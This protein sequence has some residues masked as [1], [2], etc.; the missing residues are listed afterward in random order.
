MSTID[1]TS[2]QGFRNEISMDDT[3]NDPQ[4]SSKD[5]LEL[6]SD[7]EFEDEDFSTQHKEDEEEEYSEYGKGVAKQGKKRVLAPSAS[8]GKN[9]LA[10]NL[11]KKE[12]EF[13]GTSGMTNR[14]D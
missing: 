10:K 3:K 14:N 2:V 8:N 5:N 4:L 1:T 7:P 12:C 9:K 13:C 11:K 6:S